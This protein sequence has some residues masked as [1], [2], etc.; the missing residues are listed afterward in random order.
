MKLLPAIRREKVRYLVFEIIASKGKK[1]KSVYAVDEIN[2]NLFNYFGIYSM[3]FARPWLFQEL[4]S[5]EKNMGILKVNRKYL[6][7]ART[8]LAL[9]KKI[10][11]DDVI[12]KTRIVSGT[13][14]R[15]K[16]FLN[17]AQ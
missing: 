6:N 10:K 8:A 12:I 4:Y 3:S 1:I 7:H 5:E 17:R 14:K 15:A 16:E 11:D 2:K 13:M 9:I